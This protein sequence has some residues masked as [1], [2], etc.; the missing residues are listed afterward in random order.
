[1]TSCSIVSFSSNYA[2]VNS[3]ESLTAGFKIASVGYN[4]KEILL[5]PLDQF[6]ILK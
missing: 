1:M 5:P 4:T 3:L 2:N 6:A